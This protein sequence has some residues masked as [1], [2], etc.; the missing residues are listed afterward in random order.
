MMHNPGSG[1]WDNSVR[2]SHVFYT[3]LSD[4]YSWCGFDDKDFLPIEAQSDRSMP[5][6]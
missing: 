2:K 6:F 1:L 5:V 3:D 4:S